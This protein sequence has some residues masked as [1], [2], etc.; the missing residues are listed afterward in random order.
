[1]FYDLSHLTQSEKQDVMGPI[2]DDE[3]LFLYSII[4]G[5]RIKRVLEIGGLNGYSARNFVRAGVDVCYTVDLVPVPQVSD[6]GRHRVLVKNALHL[7]PED[8]DN[9]PL[10][11]VFFDCHDMVQMDLLKMLV[12]QQLITDETVIAL[13]DTNLHY[14]NYTGSHCPYNSTLDAWIHQPVER[15]MV[16]ILKDI[17]YDVFS[18]RTRRDQ[19]DD[20]TFPYRHGLTVCQKFKMLETE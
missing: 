8:L 7:T 11:L 20:E 4:R 1:M 10:D 12:R 2:Q 6:D 15:K 14:K 13:H 5:M 19:H 17:G 3:A 16:N 18:I 9:K